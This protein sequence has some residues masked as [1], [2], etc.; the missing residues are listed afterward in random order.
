MALNIDTMDMDID[1]TLE[2]EDDPEI[3]RMRAQAA[4][5]EAVWTRPVE[6]K[7]AATNI[8]I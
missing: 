8:P 1:M 3:T 6:E 5:I 4:E 7:A 2:E